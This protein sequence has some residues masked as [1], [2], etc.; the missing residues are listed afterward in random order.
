M[1]TLLIIAVTLLTGTQSGKPEQMSYLHGTETFESC[2]QAFPI[3]RKEIA[4]GKTQKAE[5][6]HMMCAEVNDDE[7]MAIN[8]VLM[9]AMF[10]GIDM[11][12]VAQE[13]EKYI[14]TPRQ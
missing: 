10:S 11:S 5:L 3:I 2:K 8:Q 7:V 6:N 1:K 9:L 13:L 14:L 12:F 4:E